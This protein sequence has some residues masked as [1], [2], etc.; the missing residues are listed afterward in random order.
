MTA[1]ATSDE[2]NPMRP[3]VLRLATFFLALLACKFILIANYGSATPLWDQWMVEAGDLYALALRHLLPWFKLFEAYNE[4]RIVMTRLL[5]LL[6]LACN[7]QVWNPL[8]QMIVNAVLHVTALVILLGCLQQQCHEKY[9]TGLF[10]FASVLFCAP[11]SYENTLWGFQSQIY[12]VMLFSFLSLWYTTTRP[13]FTAAW[14]V[15]VLYGL[16]GLFSFGSGV[17]TF[18]AAFALQLVRQRRDPDP[19]ARQPGALFLLGGLCLLAIAITPPSPDLYAFLTIASPFAQLRHAFGNVP[20]NEPPVFA[21]KPGAESLP[22]LLEALLDVASWPTFFLAPLVYFPLL[23]FMWRQYRNPPRQDSSS[24]FVFVMGLWALGQVVLFSYGRAK[25]PLLSRYTDFY[26]IGILLNFFCLLPGFW[27]SAEVLPARFRRAHRYFPAL[28]VCLVLLSLAG[29]SLLGMRLLTRV[30]VP[31]TTASQQH[32]VGYLGSG[33]VSWLNRNE[34]ARILPSLPPQYI[35]VP[36]DDRVIRHILPPNLV[37]ENLP[38]QSQWVTFLVTN[39][40]AAGLLLLTLALSLGSFLLVTER[41]KPQ[42]TTDER[43]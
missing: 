17:T 35:K 41:E 12:F 22:E 14:N 24:W 15:G 4:H 10:L 1:N 13:P 11:Y 29:Q 36:L 20:W 30:I 25:S 18:A 3:R 31:L 38:R 39:L 28:W 6:L 16:L 21:A 7:N 34:Y 2:V 37:S 26:A 27:M 33:D 43:D 23:Q 5:D 40:C 9:R 8:L 42:P 19:Q 32:I